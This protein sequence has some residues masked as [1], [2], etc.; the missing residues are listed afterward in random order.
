MVGAHGWHHP[1]H[2]QQRVQNAC[3]LLKGTKRIRTR[4]RRW[5]ASSTPGCFGT[6]DRAVSKGEGEKREQK[7]Y[8][9]EAEGLLRERRV[10]QSR[11]ARALPLRLVGSRASPRTAPGQCCGWSKSLPPALDVGPNA[12]P[13]GMTPSTDS[14]PVPPAPHGLK[15]KK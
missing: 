15:G 9:R 7:T 6:W 5:I 8:L 3:N 4:S 14:R 11:C 2:R 12:T 1:S 10:G 13:E